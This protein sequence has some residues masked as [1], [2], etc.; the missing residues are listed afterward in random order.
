VTPMTPTMASIINSLSCSPESSSS[1][2]TLH[3]NNSN[4]DG[5]GFLVKESGDTTTT[6]LLD[7]A[8]TAPL[9]SKHP[10]YNQKGI[11]I[12]SIQPIHDSRPLDDN[13]SSS[14]SKLLKKAKLGG[15]LR[16]I[17]KSQK[18]AA[19][20]RANGTSNGAKNNGTLQRDEFI[21]AATEQSNN[22]FYIPL[23]PTASAPSI[24]R[25][26][27]KPLSARHRR[28]E[29]MDWNQQQRKED[30]PSTIK[31]KASLPTPRK[32]EEGESFF[33]NL[34]D[35]EEDND[36]NGV[37]MTTTENTTLSSAPVTAT[38]ATTTNATTSD[39][40][41]EDHCE[42]LSASQTAASSKNKDNTSSSSK[43]SPHKDSQLP[44]NRSPPRSNIVDP[45]SS[46]TVGISISIPNHTYSSTTSASSDTGSSS[47]HHHAAPIPIKQRS[48]KAKILGQFLK[49]RVETATVCLTS[50][51]HPHSLDV[52]AYYQPNGLMLSI[53]GGDPLTSNT[54][55]PRTPDTHSL[56]SLSTSPS[57]RYV[58]P[59]RRSNSV[60]RI[61][62]VNDFLQSGRGRK[63]SNA[64]ALLLSNAAA[65]RVYSLEDNDL[66]SRPARVYTR[67]R[68]PSSMKIMTPRG[69]PDLLTSSQKSMSPWE[70]AW[71]TEIEESCATSAALNEKLYEYCVMGD[72]DRV[73]FMLD[74]RTFSSQRKGIAPPRLFTVDI[75]YK[76]GE[77]KETLL[78]VAART[79]NDKLTDLLLTHGMCPLTADSKGSTPLHIACVRGCADSAIILAA[80]AETDLSVIDNAGYTPLHLSIMNH[81]FELAGDLL[82]FPVDINFKG[83]KGASILHD[84]MTRGDLEVLDFILGL[85]PQFRV[86]YNCKDTQGNTP[87][88]KAVL[89]N[90]LGLVQ[91][92]LQRRSDITVNSV[93]VKGQNIF[94]MLA[95]SSS[96]KD[97]KSLHLL[98]K[99][100]MTGKAVDMN[101]IR[102]WVNEKDKVREYTPLHLAVV[103]DNEPFFNAVCNNHERYG[104]DLN[105]V[106]EEG[107]NVGHLTMLRY[108]R[109][110]QD[111]YLRM[112][113][114]IM[115]TPGFKASTKNKNGISAKNLYK[116]LEK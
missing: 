73:K 85:P 102:S 44:N 14:T 13:S 100:L 96:M 17:T 83:S 27:L 71:K 52:D 75:H 55:T 16:L 32:I 15:V 33:E 77:D 21:S 25:A 91:R 84:A 97:E 61:Q 108:G 105:A 79:N 19:H 110:K 94:H 48:T 104:I 93:N 20:Q 11:H 72:F 56:A 47:S 65:Q 49:K 109:Y 26:S 74:V 40:K 38:T 12:P 10:Y 103:H 37:S 51:N 60:V 106:D 63:A 58:S 35:I 45:V 114:T 23:F 66:S 24:S 101:K 43:T 34:L 8:N 92:I 29:S 95:Q 1:S 76:Y 3:N 53:P 46:P 70:A 90:E 89:S 5:R 31:R 57:S 50:E 69:A 64:N 2:T 99:L 116:T 67:M 4:H 62:A 112:A 59:S 22:R 30:R 111:V 42:S 80:R 36:E 81:H 7:S 88:M 87:L 107:N 115:T 98:I 9:Y 39:E 113:R 54:V 28:Q 82:L 41:L 86:L 68:R 18:A 6:T 78:H